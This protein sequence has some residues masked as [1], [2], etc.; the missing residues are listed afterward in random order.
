MDNIKIGVRLFSTFLSIGLL[1]ML[2]PASSF[3]V[4]RVHNGQ[5]IYSPFLLRQ[6]GML[7]MYFGGWMDYGQEHDA[8][9]RSDCPWEI[10]ACHNTIKVID[11]VAVGLKQVNDPTIVR[12]PG[13]Y[14]IM[15]MTGVLPGMDGAITENNKIYYSTS[16]DNDGVNWS[17]PQLLISGAWTPSATLNQNGEVILYA[18]SNINGLVEIYNLGQSGV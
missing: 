13:G 17:P 6:D 4:N 8:I 11:A 16:W 5:N 10:A 9:Y 2:Q 1:V 14:Y 3:A 15:Y 7:R 18:N 12:M